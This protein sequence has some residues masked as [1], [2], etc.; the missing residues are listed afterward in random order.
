MTVAQQSKARPR[1]SAAARSLGVSRQHLY[2]CMKGKRQASE[3]LLRRLLE[4]TGDQGKTI[5]S[6]SF[7]TENLT[8]AQAARLLTVIRQRAERLELL[9]QMMNGHIQRQM[10]DLAAAQAV[11]AAG[12]GVQSKSK[13]DSR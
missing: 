1:I 10:A 8:P 13:P 5:M 11:F 6:D 12:Q 2:E 7:S 3:D 9:L 4:Y